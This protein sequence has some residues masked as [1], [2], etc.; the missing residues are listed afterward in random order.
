MRAPQKRSARGHRGCRLC[1]R[2]LHELAEDRLRCSSGCMGNSAFTVQKKCCGQNIVVARSSALDG[3]HVESQARIAL[4]EEGG[5][6]CGATAR[7]TVSVFVKSLYSARGRV[8]C[9]KRRSS[10]AE[11][12]SLHGPAST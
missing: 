6:R 4:A 1:W 3:V 12:V 8:A 2:T 7:S 10:L 11:T 9:W 5:V